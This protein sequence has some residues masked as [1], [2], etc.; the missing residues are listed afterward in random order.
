MRIGKMAC[1][2][3]RIP[4]AQ[5]PHWHAEPPLYRQ[6]LLDMGL[7][8]REPHFK[9]DDLENAVGWSDLECWVE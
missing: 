5:R 9:F 8:V 7:N 1:S 3:Q 6:I 2:S 4:L